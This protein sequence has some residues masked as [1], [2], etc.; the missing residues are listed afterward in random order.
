MYKVDPKPK[1][2]KM[3]NKNSGYYPGGEYPECDP[4]VSC[5]CEKAQGIM[6][7]GYFE[8]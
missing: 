3:Q 4:D 7:C 5:E 6:D 2:P 1:S 8:K